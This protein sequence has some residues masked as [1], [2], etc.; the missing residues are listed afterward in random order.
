MSDDAAMQRALARSARGH[1]SQNPPVGAVIVR[2]GAVVGE[3]ATQPVGGPH[4]EVVA[5]RM[6]GDLARGATMYVTLEPHGFH[7]RTPP[8]TEAIVAAGIARVVVS[9]RYLTLTPA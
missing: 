2:D 8:C 7:G 4:A 5:L 9:S 6:A 3:G 1:S